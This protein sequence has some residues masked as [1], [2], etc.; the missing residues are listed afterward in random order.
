MALSDF[1]VNCN[2]V[3][4]CKI[5]VDDSY[6]DTVDA[7][8]GSPSKPYMTITEAI[9]EYQSSDIYNGIYVAGGLYENET[10]PWSIDSAAG[11]ATITFQGGFSSDF[12]TLDPTLYKTSID[13]E[14]ASRVFRVN[15]KNVTIN[16]FDIS[17]VGSGIGQGAVG[18]MNTGATT[19]AVTVSDNVI[20]DNV[21]S[22]GASALY[23]YVSGANTAVVE[24]NRIYSNEDA[25]GSVIRVEGNVEM[26]NNTVYANDNDSIL[27]CSNGVQAYNNYFLSNIANYVVLTYG[28]CTFQQNNV[29]HNSVHAGSNHAALSMWN[30][31]NIVANNLITNNSGNIEASHYNSDDSTFEYNAFYSNGEALAVYEDGNLSCDPVYP[32]GVSK[33]SPE[34]VM[35][36]EGS[37]CIDKG[38]NISAMTVDYFGT[39]RPADGDGDSVAGSDPGAYEAPAA[40]IETPVIDGLG[41]TLNPFS[42]NGDG[43]SDTTTITFELNVDADVTIDILNSESVVVKSLLTAEPKTVG[44]VTVSWDGTE[45]G[46]N[47]V[48]DGEYTAMVSVENA[49]GADSSDVPVIIDTVILTGNEVCAGFADVLKTDEICPAVEYVAAKGI[50]EGYPDGTFGSDKVI[51]RVETT[52]VTL[53]GFGKTL[54]AD[55]GSDQGFSDVEAGEWYMIYVRTAKDL[56]ILEGYPDGTLKPAQ[57]INR[58]EM[59]KV[60]FITAGTDLSGVM[61]TEAPYVDT[62]IDAGSEWFLK[63]VQFSKDNALVDASADGKFYPAEGMKRGDVAELFYRYD[64]AGV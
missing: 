62:P 22:L 30:N 58:V 40:F 12:E 59:L 33:I 35:I 46:G 61:I 20:H 36:G 50:F 15:D 25:A 34:D 21:S 24:N 37:D 44:T 54:L 47:T 1:E 63:Y 7:S 45:T 60:F 29:S 32:T 64:Q 13:A 18:I 26:K 31:G 52:K 56:G 57:Q 48:E 41:L 53:L 55:D 51:N 10:L 17:G 8:D 39:T 42:P 2:V 49:S 14:N 23:L 38:K 3:K 11:N 16:G 27:T 28:S 19:Y 5:Y 4:T 6:D 9:T 43:I